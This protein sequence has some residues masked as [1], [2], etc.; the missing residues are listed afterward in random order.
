M[1]KID[2]KNRYVGL[3]LTAGDVTEVIIDAV[4]Q[5][6]ENV[7]VTR[8]PGYIKLEAINK[9]VINKDSVEEIL[10]ENW[11]TE[12]LQA[13]VTSYYGFMGEWDDDH[14]VIQWENV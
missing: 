11:E 12:D 5:D 2:E 3:D 9:L 8:F 6:N 13:V 14:I 1:T 7:R 10:G 4:Q